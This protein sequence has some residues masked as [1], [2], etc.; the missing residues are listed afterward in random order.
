MLTKNDVKHARKQIEF[1]VSSLENAVCRS[2]YYEGVHV[3]LLPARLKLWFFLLF[4]K[5]WNFGAVTNLVKSEKT[6]ES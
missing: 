5:K 1:Q 3:S 4:N 2:L 6:L